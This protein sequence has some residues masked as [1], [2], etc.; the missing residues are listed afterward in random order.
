M[1]V[2]PRRVAEAFWFIICSLFPPAF[3]N[4][5]HFC[6]AT[7]RFIFSC[8]APSPLVFVL[9]VVIPHSVISRLVTVYSL[10]FLCLHTDGSLES[11]H[12]IKLSTALAPDLFCLCLLQTLHFQS[13]LFMISSK[14]LRRISK[15][16]RLN[17]REEKA[18]HPETSSLRVSIPLAGRSRR[19]PG[20]RQKGV[21]LREC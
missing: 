10:F 1:K 19:D 2:K 11:C 14:N 8:P 20:T 3:F 4:G 13:S 17:L 7:P 9:F 18:P 16:R 6:P 21:L 5:F 12:T 15:G